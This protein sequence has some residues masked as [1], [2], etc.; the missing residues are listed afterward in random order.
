MPEAENA[1]SGGGEYS[2]WP[3]FTNWSLLRW[4]LLCGVCVV[5]LF[6]LCWTPKKQDPV[7]FHEA[8]LMLNYLVVGIVWACY[9]RKKQGAHSAAA[10][11]RRR[12]GRAGQLAE[13]RARKESGDPVAFYL[14]AF[15]LMTLAERFGFGDATHS[16][17]PEQT[18]ANREHL[19]GD[20]GN[21]AI[22]NLGRP[23]GEGIGEEKCAVDDRRLRTDSVRSVSAC[24]SRPPTEPRLRP[25]LLRAASEP[26][27][28]I[29]RR[30]ED[31][32]ARVSDSVRT[33][34]PPWNCCSN[35]L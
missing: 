26:V 11:R 28:T 23:F 19:V 9:S 22:N 8:F 15:V 7:S 13:I 2:R 30:I 1:T 16:L 27:M 17:R 25:S 6:A 3:E 35:T 20:A 34:A 4:L 5:P 24:S 14:W 21:G 33:H 12:Q 10:G 18:P 29:E 32:F 31:L